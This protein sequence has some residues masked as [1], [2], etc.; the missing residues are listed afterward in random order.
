MSEAVLQRAFEPFFTTKG[1]GEGSGLGLSLVHGIVNQRQGHVEI[2]SKVGSGTTVWV[3]L[4][5]FEHPLP[6][7]IVEEAPRKARGDETILL[8]EDEEIVR[9]YVKVGLERCGYK[10]FDAPNRSEA[11]RFAATLQEPIHL[12]LTNLVMPGISGRE[13]AQ[14]LAASRSGIRTLFMSGYLEED[15]RQN[16]LTSDTTDFLRKPFTLRTLAETVRNLLDRP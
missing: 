9:K 10:V 11:L 5:F 14:Q 3:Y 13:L 1:P 16:G 8:A 4:P 7:P 15:A 12:L 2:T 6:Q